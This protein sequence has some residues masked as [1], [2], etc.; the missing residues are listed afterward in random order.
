MLMVE[1]K[2]KNGTTHLRI[3]CKA[4]G[5]F[6]QYAPTSSDEDFKMPFGKHKGKRLV[7]VPKEYLVWWLCTEPKDGNLKKRVERI[8]SNQLKHE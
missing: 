4:C 6:I 1:Q 8:L 5:R 3:D 7:E 2:F